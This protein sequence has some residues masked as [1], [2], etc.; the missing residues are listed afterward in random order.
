MN[1]PPRVLTFQLEVLYFLRPMVRRGDGVVHQGL[2]VVVEVVLVEVE[3]IAVDEAHEAGEELL[4]S[5]GAEVVFVEVEL[6]NELPPL[7][8]E[9]TKLGLRVLIFDF[10]ITEV[11]LDGAFPIEAFQVVHFPDVLCLLLPKRLVTF[12]RS[13]HRLLAKKETEG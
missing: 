3:S 8:Q 4:H 11:D 9:S 12:W 1:E 7:L 10:A 13:F 2:G 5:F 6:S